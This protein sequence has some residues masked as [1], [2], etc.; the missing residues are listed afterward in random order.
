MATAETVSDIARVPPEQRTAAQADKLRLSF[1]NQ[2]APPQIRGAHNRVTQLER[3]RDELWGS[4][5]TV[6][7]MEEMTPRRKTY[8]LNRGAYDNPAEEVFPDVPAMLPPLRD[9]EEKNRLSF[10]RWIVDPAN[11]L[12]SRV[13]VNRFWQMYFGTGLVKSADNFGSQGEFPSHP[14]LLDWLATTFVDSDWDLSLI[15]I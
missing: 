3:E 7:V 10:A 2:Y 8:R 4:F 13:T 11:P 5:P 1:L 12:T 6:M 9:S 14:E 15:H